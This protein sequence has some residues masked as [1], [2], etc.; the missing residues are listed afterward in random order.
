M[1][2][3]A[4]RVKLHSQIIQSW[5]SMPP[6]LF[7]FYSPR[8]TLEWKDSSLS[9]RVI[10]WKTFSIF[11]GFYS[12]FSLPLPRERTRTRDSHRTQ[13]NGEKVFQFTQLM[14]RH[15]A[16]EKIDMN[17]SYLLRC[18]LCFGVLGVDGAE[19]EAVDRPL[20]LARRLFWWRSH[21]CHCR[22]PCD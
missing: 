3:A 18:W 1:R 8:E 22:C 11:P 16:W 17:K 5:N 14:G 19:V 4:E 7:S 6:E 21:Y 15:L 9:N 10:R 13:K 2:T 12:N 20:T